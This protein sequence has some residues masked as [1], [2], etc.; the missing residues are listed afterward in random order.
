MRVIRV[1]TP[2]LTHKN[3]S[4]RLT[5]GRN[6][7]IYFARNTEPPAIIISRINRMAA[8]KNLLILP[9]IGKTDSKFK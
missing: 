4:G 9:Y 2:A 6:L 1:Y 7:W 8:E 5:S 3:S